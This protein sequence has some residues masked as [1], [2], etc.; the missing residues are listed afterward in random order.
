MSE[1]TVKAAQT[2]RVTL[3]LALFSTVLAGAAMA[4]D[5]GVCGEVIHNDAISR[6][7][8]SSPEP[9]CFE[10]YAP[11]AGIL[12]AE[13]SVPAWS[14][15]EPRLDLLGRN[16]SAPQEGI[17]EL[18]YLE[19]SPGSAVVDVRVPGDYLV[20]VDAQQ[21]EL[22][23]EGYKVAI[24]FAAVRPANAPAVKGGD[25]EEDEPDPD[26]DPL[27]LDCSD[28]STARRAVRDLCRL[29]LAD[30]H[31]DTMQCASPVRPGRELSAEIR[32]GLGDDD[33]F[34]V[35]ALEELR[36]VRIG[37]TGDLDTFGGLYD[38][39]GYRLKTAD[40]GGAAG[41]FRLV[42]TLSPGRYFV[43]VASRD[44]LE[45]PYGLIVES[46]DP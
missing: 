15:A 44:G 13:V 24:G 46:D 7:V 21:P 25:P 35:F 12:V 32:N 36:T 23:L 22:S 11:A 45:G 39:R 5:P 38:R 14:Q 34:F 1:I 3:F 9:Q 29:S 18:A 6:R 17:A 19:R 30:D 20:C 43:R 41:N 16:E 42:K 2:F 27:R 31:G 37:T 33:D 40:D 4:L 8:V 26:T 28:R 10:T